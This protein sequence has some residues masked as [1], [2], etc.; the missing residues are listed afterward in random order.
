MLGQLLPLGVGSV[1]EASR[2]QKTIPRRGPNS[3]EG[4]RR[5]GRRQ[6]CG[7]GTHT[8]GTG[9]TES[10]AKELQKL[11]SIAGGA[12]CSRSAILIDEA[13][14]KSHHGFNLIPCRAELAAQP[15]DMDVHG[16]RLDRMLIPP[17][18]FE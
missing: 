17:D 8:A 16:P 4:E 6:C 3:F 7:K 9:A 14:A 10:G 13:I 18:S 11:T 2:Q 5:L 12:H 1:L 15:S